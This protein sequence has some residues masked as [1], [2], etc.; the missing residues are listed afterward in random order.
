MKKRVSVDKYTIAHIHKQIIQ[1]RNEHCLTREVSACEVSTLLGTVIETLRQHLNKFPSLGMFD[2]SSSP[3]TFEYLCSLSAEEVARYFPDNSH[4]LLMVEEKRNNFNAYSLAD[5]HRAI[6]QASGISNACTVLKIHSNTLKSWI[7]KFELDGKLLTFKSL[8]NLSLQFA[9]ELYGEQYN[10][11]LRKIS[12]LCQGTMADIHEKIRESKSL[13]QAS[14][15]LG[16]NQNTLKDHLSRFTFD[17]TNLSFAYLRNLSVP[18]AKKKFGTQYDQP[19]VIERVDLWKYSMSHLHETI[20]KVKT[21][22]QA[23]RALHSNRSSLRNHLMHRFKLCKKSSV[24]EQ[25][26]KL[27]P[28]EAVCFFGKDKYYGAKSAVTKCVDPSK[29]TAVAYSQIRS[30]EEVPETVSLVGEQK[31]FSRQKNAYPFFCPS[32]LTSTKTRLLQELTSLDTAKG[33]SIEHLRLFVE[34]E[35]QARIA[36]EEPFFECFVIDFSYLQKFLE[37]HLKSDSLNS[38]ENRK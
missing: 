19:M 33:V 5:I 4:D 20:L 16:I 10:A 27:S 35:K 3:L 38:N 14:S 37:R 17:E 29:D 13:S 7:A 32:A 28:N 24:L 6:L 36:V 2:R 18:A 12:P 11:L 8:K 9:G 30:T 25:L 31:Y 34:G 22:Q 23:A 21:F 26:K 1:L 15:L